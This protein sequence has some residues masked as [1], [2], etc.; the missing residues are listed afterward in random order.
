VASL[1]FI[2]GLGKDDPADERIGCTHN[3]MNA[4]DA[5]ESTVM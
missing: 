4:D 2:N 1:P 5:D 3:S